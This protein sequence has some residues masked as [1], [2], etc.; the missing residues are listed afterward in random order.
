MPEINKNQDLLLILTELLQNAFRSRIEY[1][2]RKIINRDI[3]NKEEIIQKNFI[4][5]NGRFYHRE[6]IECVNVSLEI[7]QKE[8]EYIFNVSN[9]NLPHTSSKEII[10]KKI[11]ELDEVNIL[12]HWQN[13]DKYTSVTGK[14]G[15]GLQI[16]KQLVEKTGGKLEFIVDET[17]QIT[18]FK[19]NYK[20]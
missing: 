2:Y 7:Q 10:E 1:H 6:C 9:Y 8:N 17:L 18:I 20:L 11:S 4:D 5:K 15:M 3:E 14:G 16:V 12:N 19:F 13:F